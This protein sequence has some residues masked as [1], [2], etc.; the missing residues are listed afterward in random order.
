MTTNSH[1]ALAK[2]S[3]AVQIEFQIESELEVSEQLTLF[4]ETHHQMQQK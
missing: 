2:K 1:M 4:G 3:S